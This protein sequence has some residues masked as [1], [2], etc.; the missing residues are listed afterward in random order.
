MG[1]RENG[2]SMGTDWDDSFKVIKWR[3]EMRATAEEYLAGQGVAHSGVPLLPEYAVAPYLSLWRCKPSIWVVVGDLPTDYFVLPHDV[4]ARIA[5]RSF[6]ERWSRAARNML[7]GRADPELAIGNP[8]DHD[9][10]RELGDL[11]ARRARIVRDIA[12]NDA[13]WNWKRGL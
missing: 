12:D 9:Q 4:T 6:S 2:K 11:L 7:D 10:Q 8:E 5:L 13:N 1:A 3:A